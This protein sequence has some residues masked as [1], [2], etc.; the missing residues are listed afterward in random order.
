MDTSSPGAGLTRLAASVRW[1]MVIPAKDWTCFP[2][3]RRNGRFWE[4]VLAVRIGPRA[5]RMVHVCLPLRD[6]RAASVRDAID[7]ARKLA[8]LL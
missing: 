4:G 6:S 3:A 1:V 7:D 5:L 2:A 8:H